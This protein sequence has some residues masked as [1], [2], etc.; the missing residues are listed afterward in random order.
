MKKIILL[1]IICQL[2][3]G[4]GD[5]DI[6]QEKKQT[7]EL[8]IEK[9]IF[10]NENDYSLK[11]S[12]GNKYFF[13]NLI[14]NGESSKTSVVLFVKEYF[15]DNSRI[16]THR[17]NGVG[18]GGISYTSSVFMSKQFF[19]IDDKTNEVYLGGDIKSDNGELQFDS[20]FI[21]QYN[22]HF[23]ITKY[24]SFGKVDWIRVGGS[25]MGERGTHNNSEDFKSNI[26]DIDISNDS[27]IYFTGYISGNVFSNDAEE[28]SY[29]LK[30]ENID[31]LNVSRNAIGQSIMITAPSYAYIGALR[32]KDGSLKSFDAIAGRSYYD[33]GSANT[34]LEI[35]IVDNKLLVKGVFQDDGLFPKTLSDSSNCHVDYKIVKG[36]GSET[37]FIAMYNLADNNKLMWVKTFELDKGRF[38]FGNA[39]FSL[40]SAKSDGI[41]VNGNYYTES[42]KLSLFGH[43]FK[44]ERGDFVAKINLEGKLIWIKDY[45][46]KDNVSYKRFTEFNDGL[47]S[48]GIVTSD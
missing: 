23:F 37:K 42:R 40:V 39:N 3:F 31:S 32:K 20:T 14:T 19:Q 16:D 11:D 13:P 17:V 25:S 28:F 33:M 18:Y 30:C 12:K 27:L 15:N 29:L 22:Q 47:Y 38:N 4:C 36:V 2:L 5:D 24:T 35:K 21:P 44:F 46:N 34:G 9:I 48:I 10:K 45:D 7:P 1:G 26:Y 6:K 41:I 8:K 43:E